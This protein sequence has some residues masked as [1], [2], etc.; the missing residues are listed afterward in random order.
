MAKEDAVLVGVG[1]QGILLASEIL[2]QTAIIS[3]HRVKTN[4][5]H[6]MAQRGGSVIAHVRYG[7]A[8]HSP[9]V[10]EGRAN[11][12]ASFEKIEALRYAHYLASD[13]VAVVS[14]QQIIPVS[15]SSG[16]ATYPE[17][18]DERLAAVFGKRLLKIDAIEIA[19]A[20][21]NSKAANVALMGAVS[22]QLSLPLKAW[23]EAIA[24]CVPE[25]FREL[26][27]EAFRKG[28]DSV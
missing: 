19:R 26:N 25:Q 24:E 28:R 23:E 8:V 15:V 7:D 14:T 5:T 10:T 6:G 3:G 16:Q 13:G 11:V 12:L 2:A 21:G 20:L 17:D 22:M 9:M 1:G 18:A 27:L 4:E